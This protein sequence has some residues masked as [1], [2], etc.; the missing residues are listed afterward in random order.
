MIFSP[1]LQSEILQ[2]LIHKGK[3]QPVQKTCLS[4]V[5]YATA[6][7]FS[8]SSE[9][10]PDL[11]EFSIKILESV[12]VYL[13]DIKFPT[14]D[15]II[16]KILNKEFNDKLIPHIKNLDD[17]E[18]LAGLCYVKYK[19]LSI[20]D[21]R[22]FDVYPIINGDLK[23]KMDL[24]FKDIVTQRCKNS[25]LKNSDNSSFPMEC[26]TSRSQIQVISSK[27]TRQK[28]FE[29]TQDLNTPKSFGNMCFCFSR[30]SQCT[31]KDKIANFY[32][33]YFIS[34]LKWG[35]F[36]NFQSF[37]DSGSFQK[38]FEAIQFIKFS[39]L[40]NAKSLLLD[41]LKKDYIKLK[42]IIYNLLSLIHIYLLE[43]YEALHYIDLQIENSTC[44]EL[45]FALNCKFLLERLAEIPSI[46]TAVALHIE[47][48][49]SEDEHFIKSNYENKYLIREIYGHTLSRINLFSDTYCNEEMIGLFTQSICK[50][51][52][53]YSILYI[54]YHNQNV[55][56]YNLASKVYI[57]ILWPDIQDRFD[58]I[59]LQN[60]KVLGL[61]VNTPEE[62]RS[63]WC[64]RI[65]LDYELELLVNQVKNYVLLPVRSKILIIL[66][67]EIAYFPF[68]LVFD[69]PA[70]RILSRDFSSLMV[71]ILTKSAFYLLDPGD[72][73][74]STKEYISSYIEQKK[75]ENDSFKG[76][77]G[78]SLDSEELKSLGDYDILLYFGHGSGK[79]YFKIATSKPKVLFLF[80]CS[81]C[82]LLSIKNFKSNG[83]CLRHFNKRRIVLGNLWDVTDKDLDK[84]TT[85]ILDDYLSG[86]NLI[87]SIHRNR[88]ECRLKYLN[89]AALV[90]YGAFSEISC[91]MLAPD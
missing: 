13:T 34:N 2:K 27:I 46:T 41:L 39:K 21:E 66:E 57:R 59:M 52:P 85:C 54:F 91:N 8:I 56:V 10:S 42:T 51:L 43:Y 14:L 61:E 17:P 20:V 90:L 83:Y 84:M 35:D 26:N 4:K 68:E 15:R 12:S 79:K 78:R 69:K 49:S 63:W 3:K 88:D 89:S 6:I 58:E 1:N 80:G 67:D 50:Q 38:L 18:I 5:K 40:K 31:S 81:S 87:E 19:Y 64:S 33:R 71:K 70:V 11:V 45:D 24:L 86:K 48:Y 76:V 36:S 72:N 53:D 60:R 47:K 28:F 32:S 55:Y 22:I 74:P 82:R 16:L 7:L 9:P 62:K 37:T 44:F 23:I 29:K 77:V 73:L 65:K 75:L 30:K 25:E